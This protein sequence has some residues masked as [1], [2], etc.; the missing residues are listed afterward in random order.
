VTRIPVATSVSNNVN[1]RAEVSGAMPGPLQW[2]CP[3]VNQ[4][5]LADSGGFS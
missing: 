3:R 2:R 5:D 1:P 4:S